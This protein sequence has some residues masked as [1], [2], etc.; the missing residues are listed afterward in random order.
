MRGSAKTDLRKASC[1]EFPRWA[2]SKVAEGCGRLDGWMGL[3]G[4]GAGASRPVVSREPANVN[5]A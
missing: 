5:Y 4:E 3:I 1:M 2:D